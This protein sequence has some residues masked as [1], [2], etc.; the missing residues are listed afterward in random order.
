MVYSA[1][2]AV[3]NAMTIN[4][5]KHVILLGHGSRNPNW[6]A[7]LE[8]GLESIQPSLKEQ[9][10]HASLAQMELGSPSLKE[11]VDAAYKTGARDFTVLPL[12]F[13]SGKH[14]EVDIPEQIS[15]IETELNDCSIELK[16]ALGELDNFW[17]FIQEQIITSGQRSNLPD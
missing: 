10:V 15:A 17:L 5:T 13:A 4:S 6:A 9:G 11:A 14:L 1:P 8:Q 2:T 7:T 3:T 16:A 12:F